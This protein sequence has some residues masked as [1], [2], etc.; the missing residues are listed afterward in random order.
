MI[1]LQYVFDKERAGNILRSLRAKTGK[2][3]EEVADDIGVSRQ[4]IYAY[5]VGKKTPTP[6]N[7]AAL[8]TYY[9]VS[10]EDLFFQLIR[11]DTGGNDI[12]FQYQPK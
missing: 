6:D 10:L 12:A 9:G 1:G 5:E 4:T 2:T 3:A 7:M 11:V 8:A